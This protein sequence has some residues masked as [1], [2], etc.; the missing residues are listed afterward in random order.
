MNT[1]ET[2]DE[3]AEDDSY[4]PDYLLNGNF[5]YNETYRFAYK[6]KIFPRLETEYP[7][8]KSS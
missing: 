2:S 7:I 4:S 3:I 8:L 5:M 1:I 6:D